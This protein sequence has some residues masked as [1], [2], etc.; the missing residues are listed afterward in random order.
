MGS[1][2]DPWDHDTIDHTF[3]KAVTES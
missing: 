3:G 2:S 1:L